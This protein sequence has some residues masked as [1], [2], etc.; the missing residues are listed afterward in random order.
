MSSAAP[1]SGAPADAA[2][3]AAQYHTRRAQLE[4]DLTSEF[5]RLTFAPLTRRA[6][7]LHATLRNCETKTAE[8]VAAADQLLRQ[9]VECAVDTLPIKPLTVR[10]PAGPNAFYPGCVLAREALGVSIMRAG[11]AMEAALRFVL[12]AVRI[13]KLLIQRDESVAD[14]PAKFIYSKMPPGVEQASVLLLDPML[15]SGG[16]SICAIKHLLSLQ[17]PLSQITFVC[18]I[19]CPAGIRNLLQAFPDLAI[20]AGTIDPELDERKYIVPG[21]GDMGDRYFGTVPPAEH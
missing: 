1:A 17:I 7:A 2:A 6:L 13:G 14:K 8:F 5:P 10:S 18:L 16:S 20:V 19:A 9:L 12:P 11:E 3:F 4:Q 21:V 15:A